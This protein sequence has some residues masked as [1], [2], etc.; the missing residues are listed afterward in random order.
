[1]SIDDSSL[2]QQL[3]PVS[4]FL[5]NTVSEP[6]Q[7]LFQSG[8]DFLDDNNIL[9]NERDV[10]FV[11]SYIFD[12]RDSAVDVGINTYLAIASTVFFL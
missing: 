3:K 4:D 9:P 1:M 10:Q 2:H 12:W 11:K 5:R 8:R 6:C 7:N